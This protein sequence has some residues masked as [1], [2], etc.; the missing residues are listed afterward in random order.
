MKTSGKKG[1]HVF[2]PLDRKKT[3]FEDAKRFSKAVAVIMQKN[4]PDLVTSKMDKQLRANKVFINWSAE[5]ASKTMV[6]VYS[7]RAQEKPSVS[8]PLSWENLAEGV[9][10]RDPEKLRGP[11]GRRRFAGRE[12][13]GFFQRVIG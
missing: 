10:A 8:F 1:L 2:A 11:C 7:L 13:R 9:K 6:C 5:H 4:Y 12:K 3:K